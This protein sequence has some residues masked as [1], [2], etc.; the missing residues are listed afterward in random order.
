MITTLIT[1]RMP[2]GELRRADVA[3]KTNAGYRVA[4]VHSFNGYT[5]IR[6]RVSAAHGFSESNRT[7]KFQVNAA[8]ADKVFSPDNYIVSA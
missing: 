5:K 3:P 8:D 4:R 1:V 6:G 7:H 2:N